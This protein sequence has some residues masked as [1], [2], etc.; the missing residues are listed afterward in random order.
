M[1]SLRK[2]SNHLTKRYSTTALIK[3][4]IVAIKSV[5]FIFIFD[6]ILK[7]LV[8]KREN[9][10]TPKRKTPI[11]SSDPRSKRKI[12]PYSVP[13]EKNE[14][15]EIAKVVKR[16]KNDEKPP[17]ISAMNASPKFLKKIENSFCP[18]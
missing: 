14:L 7:I 5:P 18:G 9:P 15:L 10:L 6:F 11:N 12:I 2:K 13:L 4:K 8:S 3:S 16:N 17:V 1:L